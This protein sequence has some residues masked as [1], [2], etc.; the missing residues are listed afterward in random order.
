MQVKISQSTT[1]CHQYLI[2]ISWAASMR[3]Q[4]IQQLCW[5]PQLSAMR[6]KDPTAKALIFTQF[7]STLEWLMSRLTEEGYGYRTI[8]GS[9]PMKK[10]SEVS[11]V[12]ISCSLKR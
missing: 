6:Q 4:G 12:F 11:P 8:S 9:M 3:S 10:R 7:S 2:A 1:F 5:V